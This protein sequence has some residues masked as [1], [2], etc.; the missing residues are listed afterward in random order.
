MHN[1]ELG[2]LCDVLSRALE[3]NASALKKTEREKEKYFLQ[4]K[5]IAFVLDVE[6][7]KIV[8]NSEK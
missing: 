4:K 8:Y 7:K 1:N 2:L 3:N 6:V 5:K